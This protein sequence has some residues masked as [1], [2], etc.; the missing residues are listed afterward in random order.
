MKWKGNID[1][2]I[3]VPKRKMVIIFW[4]SNGNYWEWE[5]TK[6]IYIFGLLGVNSQ[7][8]GEVV[9]IIREVIADFSLPLEVKTGNKNKKIDFCILKELIQKSVSDERYI[10]FDLVESSLFKVRR[11]KKVLGYGVVIV[12]DDRRYEFK[13]S[14]AEREPA[15]YGCGSPDGL[16]IIRRRYIRKATKHEFG[17]MIG[18]DEHH[19]NCVMDYYCTHEVFCVSCKNKIKRIWGS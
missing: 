1:Y 4:I 15:V 13:N 12:V 7:E 3:P 8:L 19:R 10:D 2:Q 14:H 16:V 5:K 6:W 17:H 11:S 9:H 18:L